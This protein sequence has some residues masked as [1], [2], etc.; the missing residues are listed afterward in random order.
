M[1]GTIWN[2][3]FIQPITSGLLWLTDVTGDLG[4]SIILL[5][6]I[7]QLIM[8]PLRV[9]SLK[10][11]KKMRAL[12]PKLNDLKEKHKDDKMALA[13]AQMD[14]YKE[15]EVNPFGGIL[16]TLLSI[17]IIFAL[18]RVLLS[19]LGS[20]EGL[21][22]GFLWF[23]LTKPDPLYILPVIV[24][25]SQLILSQMMMSSQPKQQESKD[26]KKSDGPEDMMQS[27]QSQM[28]YIFPILSGV[29]T[30]SLPAG[31]GVYW[32]TSLVFAI[33]QHQA[34]ERTS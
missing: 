9:P 4:I 30:A 19:T 5:T 15:H 25:G 12:Q 33:I 2:S 34:I 10:S 7:L 14:M 20:V 26:G 28:K 29:I 32:L 18:Y 6:I 17:P 8:V 3:V 16:P 23:D 22:T 31:A 24:A 11:A 13:Q 27:M 1:L 21:S